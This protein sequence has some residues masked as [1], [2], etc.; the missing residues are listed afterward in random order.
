MEIIIA[1]EGDLDEAVVQKVICHAGGIPGRSYGKQGI[2]YLRSKIRGYNNA[3][4]R[5]PWLVVADLDHPN[6]QDDCAPERVR[7]WL[8]DDIQHCC[9]RFAVPQIEAWLMGDLITLSE[10]L[11]IERAHVD[12]DPE[13]LLSAKQGMLALARRSKDKTIRE[14]M[15][16]RNGSGRSE[17]SEYTSRLIEYAKTCWRPEVAAERVDS[18]HRAIAC[19]RDLIARHQQD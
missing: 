5:H 3:A 12:K 11:S 19:L 14:Q 17:G 4:R 15:L 16:P 6:S 8:S 18:L 1:V 13:S 10:F 2:A 9:L 7:E